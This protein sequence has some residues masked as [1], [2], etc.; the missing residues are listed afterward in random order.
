M[1]PPKPLPTDLKSGGKPLWKPSLMGCSGCDGHLFL[2]AGLRVMRVRQDNTMTPLGRPDNRYANW[3]GHDT[4]YVCAGCLKP[5]IEDNGTL[6]DL[7]ANIT[8]EE[9][10]TAL[11]RGG[12]QLPA[13]RRQETKADERD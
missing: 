8:E 6:V 10:A 4:V 1:T 2:N 13:L 5:V 3:E 12:Y 7:S 9:V 11:L